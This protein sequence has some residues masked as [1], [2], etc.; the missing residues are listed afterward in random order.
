MLA[1]VLC[2]ARSQVSNV[3][4]VSFDPVP[5]VFTFGFEAGGTFRLVFESTR[6]GNIR[7]L[8]LSQSELAASN[9]SQFGLVWSGP[10]PSIAAI[11]FSGPVGEQ[12][13]VW[14]GTV[15]ERSV[16]TLFLWNCDCG[17]TAFRLTATTLNP[18]THLDTRHIVMPRLYLTFCVVYSI[19]AL[20]WIVNTLC[21]LRF[22][23]PLHTLFVL[24]P[25][26]RAL[27]MAVSRSVWVD[28][29]ISDQIRPWKTPSLYLL[30]VAF[31]SV[32]LA[33][34]SFACAGL[35]IYR[36]KVGFAEHIEMIVTAIFVSASYLGVEYIVSVRSAFLVIGMISFS[37]VW[38]IKQAAVSVV[39]VTGLMK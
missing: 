38:Y 6:A 15:L 30:G 4:F 37:S 36:R 19:M 24:L 25:I 26:I 9:S 1:A 33:G 29:G 2:A 3:N 39:L 32:T 12:G 7:G 35:S 21:F 17:R 23:V 20:I 11:N 18:T 28:L 16:Y 22:R 31:Y 5:H 27:S 14:Q 34:I 10:G 8:L 13:G